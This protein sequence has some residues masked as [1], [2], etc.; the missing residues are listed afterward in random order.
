MFTAAATDVLIDDCRL[1][2]LNAVDAN[3]TGFAALTGF[4]TRCYCHIVTD[5]QVTWI[6]TPGNT[7][8]GECYGTNDDGECG[9][10]I[11]VVSI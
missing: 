7:M 2:N 4:I 3:I 9:L 11:G 8:T 10:I 1:E 6:T 5:A